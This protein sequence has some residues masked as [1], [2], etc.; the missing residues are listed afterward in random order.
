MKQ[1]VEDRGGNPENVATDRKS[2]TELT[3]INKTNPNHG[4]NVATDRKS[5]TE[6][7]LGRPRLVD[8]RA[9][10]ATDRKSRTEL[11]QTV[12]LGIADSLQVATDRKSRTEL[13]HC[14]P[15]RRHITARRDGQKI[16]NGI[17]TS[18]TRSR[19]RRKPCR[20]G[21]KIQNGIETRRGPI[22]L[23][24]VMQSRR[25]ENPERN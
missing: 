13:K 7:K 19:T 6:L 2:R 4:G 14:I 21:Q 5:R 23:G 17:E 8:Q 11:K 10:V 12:R 15:V 1:I 22:V 9:H 18:T 16:Q 24:I 20:D 25:T 3:L